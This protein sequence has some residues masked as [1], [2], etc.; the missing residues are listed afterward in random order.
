MEIHENLEKYEV[1]IEKTMSE[2]IK[3]LY[4]NVEK[5]CTTNCKLNQIAMSIC[6]SIGY[7][8]FKRW[9]RYRSK[10]FYKL[11]LKLN[12]DIYSKFKII[13]DFKDYTV[14]YKPNSLEEHLKAWKN[15]NLNSIQELGE[16]QKTY[17]ENTGTEC[18]IIRKL[19]NIL[20]KDYD[21]ICKYY[22][23][24]T[25]S[26]WLTLDMHIVDDSIHE[27]YKCKEEKHER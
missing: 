8:G 6:Q 23:R 25:E 17:F 20:S 26:D 19:I 11:K 27:Y 7:N 12:S 1:P 9:H 5:I 2:T 3:T 10:E 22:T 21:K 24:F 16:L 14:N 4:E 15:S 18:K 13:S